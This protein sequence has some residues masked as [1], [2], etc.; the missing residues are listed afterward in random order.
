MPMGSLDSPPPHFFRQ[1]ASALSK[2]IVFSAL[3]LFMMVADARFKLT[4]TVRVVVATVLYPVQWAV[5]RPVL[6]AQSGASYFES[7]SSAQ[8][9]AQAAHQKLR[10]QSQRANQVEQLSLENERLRKLLE[11]RDQVKTPGLT[12]QVLY[13]WP[14]PIHARLS[15]TRA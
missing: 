8:A 9:E 10:L 1:G 3:A 7:L 15:S 2:L 14:T 12:A 5:M 4:Q 13:N 11:L 6:W